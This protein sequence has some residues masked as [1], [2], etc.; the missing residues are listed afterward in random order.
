MPTPGRRGRA[1]HER[2]QLA[3]ERPRVEP[4]ELDLAEAER[5]VRELKARDL[6]AKRSGD[7]DQRPELGRAIYDL[8][9]AIMAAREAR[10]G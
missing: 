7:H 2:E 9:R 1:Y 3:D 8:V 10:N 5:M 6:A 4:G